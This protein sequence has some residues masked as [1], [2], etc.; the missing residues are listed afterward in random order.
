[1]SGRGFTGVNIERK[2]APKTYLGSFAFGGILGLSWTPCIGP[3]LVAILV[4]AST[5]DSA[6]VGGLLLF[7]YAIG[8]AVPLIALAYFADRVNKESRLWKILSG[9]EFSFTL[10]KRKMSVHSASLISGIIFL[11]L[12]YVIF[13]GNLYT[14]NELVG[15]SSFQKWIFGL[16]EG[17]L[18]GLG[19]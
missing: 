16:E 12:G 1:M 5:A 14:F 13:S 4:L 3:I 11:V 6:F 19:Q 7:A 8:L 15:T 9:R 10:G 2:K 18:R 17:L